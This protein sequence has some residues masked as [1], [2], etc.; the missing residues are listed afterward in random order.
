MQ[1]QQIY[2]EILKAIYRHSSMLLEISKTFISRSSLLLLPKSYFLGF[3]GSL[4]QNM[5]TDPLICSRTSM[6]HFITSL[7]AIF[8]IKWSLTLIAPLYRLEKTH[9]FL[10]VD[11]AWARAFDS[12]S[13]ERAGFLCPP[14]SLARCPCL[15]QTKGPNH[16]S[17]DSHKTSCKKISFRFSHSSLS[18]TIVHVHP[19]L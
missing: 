10:Q 3:Q 1:S 12:V 7:K 6:P 14:T 18:F 13:R 9:P 17:I 5:D 15:R 8:P 19:H 16:P 2:D 11:A 4:V